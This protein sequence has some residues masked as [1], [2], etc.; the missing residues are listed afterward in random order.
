MGR[1][2][3]DGS[4]KCVIDFAMTMLAINEIVG[5]YAKDNPASGKVMA[6]LGFQ[7]EKD[8]PY[9]CNDGAVIR[10]GIQCRLCGGKQNAKSKNGGF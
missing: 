10:Q 8:I 9:A 4:V 2:L 7:Y 1:G 5:R 6:K 3:C